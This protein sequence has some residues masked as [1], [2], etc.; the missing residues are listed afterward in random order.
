MILHTICSVFPN[1]FSKYFAFAINLTF[2]MLTNFILYKYISKFLKND[3]LGLLATLLYSLSAGAIS[4]VIYL[5]MY[6]MLT[7]FV[8][9]NLYIHTKILI[10]N[11]KLNKK[12]IFLFSVIN[13]LGGYTHYYFILYE[14]ILAS[15]FCDLMIKNKKIDE[16]K[17]YV[18][19]VFICGIINIIIYP[20]E[21]IAIFG[22][23]RG[24]GTT[25]KSFGLS[26]TTV[27]TH[28]I[29]KIKVYCI[30]IAKMFFANNI[31]I[32]FVFIVACIVT[33][34]YKLKQ[35][36][37]IEDI[38]KIIIIPSS[39][40]LIIISIISPFNSIRYVACVF[41]I[42]S[43]IIIY[44]VD[45]F[46][47]NICKI[48]KT[49]PIIIIFIIGISL[50]A[51]YFK[52]PYY[53]YRNYDIKDDNN[54]A[55]FIG[56][57]FKEWNKNINKFLNYDK[58]LIL[59]Y[60]NFD[61]KLIQGIDEYAKKRGINTKFSISKIINEQI[62]KYSNNDMELLQKINETKEID[63]ITVF[64]SKLVNQQ[65]AI[66]KITENTK[67]KNYKYNNISV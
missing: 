62:S 61:E 24:L 65:D 12:D 49:V 58:T 3:K 53:T 54:I 6:A 25:I 51:I 32:L 26:I 45:Y 21:F 44:T 34:I 22:G 10:N 5:R 33:L 47:K 57:S 30:L 11:Y 55:V 23:E 1:I 56:T 67:F 66:N 59:R 29:Y 13:I 40:Y 14:F 15:V 48:E 63:K 18:L 52:L 4:I 50:T 39:I 46:M 60:D 17:K 42:I 8:I 36:K 7:F 37:H 41:P 35:K 28:F 2:I 27:I 64:I 38:W 16:L 9:S 19:T 31:Y 20:Y 43:L